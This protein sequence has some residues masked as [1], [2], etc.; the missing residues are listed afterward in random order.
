[1]DRILV[2]GFRNLL[3][4]ARRVEELL[5]AGSELRPTRRNLRVGDASRPTRPDAGPRSSAR[6]GSAASSRVEQGRLQDVQYAMPR[7][8]HMRSERSASSR[9][10]PR[11]RE[12]DE[13][14]VSRS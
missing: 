8:S 3:E 9:S 12:I 4:D 2:E 11:H 14:G 13:R 7:L 6:P 10:R 5:A 1:V